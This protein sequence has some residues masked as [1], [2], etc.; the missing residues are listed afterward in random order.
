QAL[1]PKKD[2]DD[3]GG[4][5]KECLN[6]NRRET[7][8]A[9]EILWLL[10]RGREGGCHEPIRWICTNT[11]NTAPEPLAAETELARL[12]REHVGVEG[13]RAALQPKIEEARAKLKLA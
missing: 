1:Y 12:F 5:V 13:R 9:E 10:R 11:G 6:P 3:A 2:P 7:F 8:D 4:D